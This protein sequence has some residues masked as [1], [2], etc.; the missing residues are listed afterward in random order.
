MLNSFESII[1][2]RSA[3][4]TYQQHRSMAGTKQGYW[5]RTPQPSTRVL[6]EFES[7]KNKKGRFSWH[8]RMH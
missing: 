5:I 4:T 6:Y 8:G 3:G 2:P 1:D 7:S